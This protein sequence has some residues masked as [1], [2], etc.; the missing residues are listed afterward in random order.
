MSAIETSKGPVE[1]PLPR[2]PYAIP[3]GLVAADQRRRLLEALP[4]AIAESGFEATTVDQIVKI[5]Q[6]RRNSFY[7]Q[8]DDKRDCFAAAYEIAQERLLGVL[9]FQCYTR[10]GL[11]DR[12]SAALGAALDLLGGD[13]VLTRLIVVEAPAAGG[14]VAARH[15]EWLD[16]YGRMLHFAA[17]GDAGIVPPKPSV[18]PAVVGGI[19]SL[20]K[21]QVLAGGTERLPQLCPELVQFALSFYGS[22]EPS[23]T[24]SA[25]DSDEPPQPQS[26]ERSSLLE[27]AV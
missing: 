14:R 9:T 13:P 27:P 8:F 11:A 17:M 1:A 15:H 21:Q 20:I 24:F 23:V 26:P 4:L 7:E 22:L 25:G 6:V 19:V 18:E 12:A 5:A 3:A 16:R 10:T 2:G